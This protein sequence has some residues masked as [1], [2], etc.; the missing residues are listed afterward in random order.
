MS[1]LTISLYIKK[2]MKLYNNYK[3]E[4]EV[5]NFNKRHDFYI[6]LMESQ[7]ILNQNE[8]KFE[9]VK[10]ALQQ[11]IFSNNFRNN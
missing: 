6:Y 8:Q 1:N 9:R 2:K 11:E 4:E 7:Y 3:D 10:N 5:K